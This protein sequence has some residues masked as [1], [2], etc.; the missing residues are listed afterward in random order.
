MDVGGVAAK[1]HLP[2]SRQ[3]RQTWQYNNLAY[4]TAGHVAEVLTG[5]PWEQAVQQRLLDPLGMKSTCFS[6]RDSSDGDY[7]F[8]YSDVAGE[9]QL[10]ELPSS[11]MLL[12]PG[13]IVSSVDDLAQWALARLGTR[14]WLPVVAA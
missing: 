4:D 6:A 11:S 8:P 12:P 14:Q 1:Q 3:L 7:A 2:L 5:L 9:L 13:G 10:Q